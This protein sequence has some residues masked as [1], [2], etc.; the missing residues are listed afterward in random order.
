MPLLLLGSASPLFTPNDQ[1]W[2]PSINLGHGKVRINEEKQ[3]NVI[4]E[5]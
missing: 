1:D 5:T 2:V 4:H 3:N